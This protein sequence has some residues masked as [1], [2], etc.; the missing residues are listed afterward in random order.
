MREEKIKYRSYSV[1]VSE[2]DLNPFVERFSRKIRV[3]F[4]SPKDISYST[5][6]VEG[7]INVRVKKNKNNGR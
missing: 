4:I 7:V 1:T 5:E 3:N 6:Y 2:K